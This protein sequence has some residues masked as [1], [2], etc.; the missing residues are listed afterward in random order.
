[1]AD[2]YRQVRTLAVRLLDEAFERLT[3]ERVLPRS[4]YEPWIH[5]GSE[6]EGWLIMG[7]PMHDVFTASLEATFP[8][9]FAG[10]VGAK[11]FATQYPH[12]LVTSAVAWLTR[13]GQPYQGTQSAALDVIRSFLRYVSSSAERVVV[14]YAVVGI[15]TG[16]DAELR[17]RGL[18]VIPTSSVGEPHIKAVIE[19]SIPGAGYALKDASLF[20]VGLPSCLF[21]ASKTEQLIESDRFHDAFSRGTATLV[22]RLDG[23]V[24]GLRLTTSGTIHVL[25][26]AIGG[27]GPFQMFR[28]RVG[29][30]RFRDSLADVRRVTTIDASLVRRLDRLDGL[31]RR[32]VVPDRGVVPT[33]SIAGQRFNRS[34]GGEYWQERLI[35]LAIGLEA[36]M[37]QEDDPAELSL[38]LRNRAATLLAD[39]HD[40][41]ARIFDDLGIIYELRSRVMH[42][43]RQDPKRLM[44]RIEKV[45][46]AALRTLPG[47]KTEFFIDRFRDLVRRAILARLFLAQGESPAWSL[48]GAKDLDK[49]LVDDLERQR[50]RNLWRERARSLGLSGAVGPAAQA[51]SWHEPSERSDKSTDTVTIAVDEG[52]TAGGS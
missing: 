36:A 50:L 1:M 3:Q 19:R 17:T 34:F 51:T 6:F 11:D 12:A 21:I 30:E 24:S 5:V 47:T 2:R 40:E 45:P 14:V 29:E 32:A 44:A 43:S 39:P 46:A 7:L 38:R 16:D 20:R 27:P 37:G 18:R 23:L 13:M 15:R 31:W 42:G 10:G 8:A 26:H 33:L 41:A 48:G 35:D 52:S 49:R 4:R 22:N 9:R 25:A 28:P